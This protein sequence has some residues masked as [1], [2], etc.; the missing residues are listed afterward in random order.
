MEENKIE[1]SK[2]KVVLFILLVVAVLL[3]I[4]GYISMQNKYI[5][6]LS[7]HGLDIEYLNNPYVGTKSM[8]SMDLPESRS[9]LTGGP[10]KFGENIL[11][12]SGVVVSV[13][14]KGYIDDITNGATQIDFLGHEYVDRTKYIALYLTVYNNTDKDYVLTEE[15]LE[16]GY[17][18][19]N[20][21]YFKKSN[22]VA[23]SKVNIKGIFSLNTISPYTIREGYVFIPVEDKKID[24]LYFKILID[25]IPV[26]FRD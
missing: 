16:I 10:F 7:K 22:F 4:V 2:T 17:Y 5:T 25:N 26:I 18:K 6:N 24:N 1:I 20:K 9:I 19:E 3:C 11:M 13:K 14:N 15:D 8:T 23:D 21:Q 12:S